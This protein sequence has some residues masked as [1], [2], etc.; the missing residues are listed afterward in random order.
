VYNLAHVYLNGKN[1]GTLWK[2]P[3]SVDITDFAVAGQNSLSIEV[4]NLWPNR[5]IGDAQTPVAYD[6]SRGGNL[7]V[8][9][10]WYIGNRPKSDDG[11]IS[12]SVVKLFNADDPLYDSGHVGPVVVRTAV[13]K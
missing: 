1:L 10:D 6:Y 8:L 9:P 3:F 11:K 7:S 4:T 12:F 5:L 2:L 13:S